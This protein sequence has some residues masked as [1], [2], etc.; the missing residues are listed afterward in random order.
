MKAKSK[1]EK[2]N[3][4]GKVCYRCGGVGHFKRVCPTKDK[5][6]GQ[7]GKNSDS[8]IGPKAT[9]F[10]AQISSHYLEVSPRV[11]KLTLSGGSHLD[12]DTILFDNGSTHTMTWNVEDLENT[13]AVDAKVVLPR[14]STLEV[15]GIGDLRITT[16]SADRE[17]DDELTVPD[18]LLVP[19]L[20]VKVFAQKPFGKLGYGIHGFGNSFDFLDPTEKPYLQWWTTKSRTSTNCG[21]SP[22]QN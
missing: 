14:G 4:K 11:A 13:E 16:L 9:L 17:P 3:G 1:G 6:D 21:R 18:A 19:E 10:N 2:K 8:S 15:T 5:S 20:Q 12:K 22:R 7:E